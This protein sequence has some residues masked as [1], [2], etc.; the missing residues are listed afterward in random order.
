MRYLGI[1][2]GTIRTGLAVSD[3]TNTFAR[4]LS[5]IPTNDEM[6]GII[7][8]YILEFD[9]EC[10]VVGKPLSVRFSRVTEQ[11]ECVVS[12]VKQLQLNVSIDIVYENERFTSK[13]I[14]QEHQQEKNKPKNID[15]LSACLILQSYLDKRDS[16]RHETEGRRHGI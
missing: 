11:T 15:S 8:D 4:E 9:I 14:H 6:F 10:I 13:I 1:D 5:I 3:P 7:Q 12:F 16:V 2:Y